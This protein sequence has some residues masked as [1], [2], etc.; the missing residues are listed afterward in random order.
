MTITNR[1]S[2][3]ASSAALK[4]PCVVATTA[5]ITLSALQTIDGVALASGDRVLVKNQTTDTE[6]G[7]WVADTGDW[8]RAEDFDGYDDVVTGTIMTVIQGTV[9][10]W[11][12]WRVTTSGDITPGTTSITIDSGFFDDAAMIY[13]IA[14]GT[15]AVQRTVQDKEREIIS[16]YDFLTTAQK[17]AVINDDY[18]TVTRAN[19]TTA[20]NNC[21]TAAT[22]AVWWPPGTYRV[23][24]I[25]HPDKVIFHRGSGREETI[26]QG[27]S[28][29][30][31]DMAYGTGL[32]QGSTFQDMAIRGDGAVSSEGTNIALDIDNV[33]TNLVRVQ[34]THAG[35]GIAARSLIGSNWH[36]V[37]AY[38]ED[39]GFRGLPSAAPHGGTESL[40]YECA[41]YYMTCSTKDGNTGTGTGFKVD[42]SF[43]FAGNTFVNLSSEYVGNGIVLD[44]DDAN[45]TGNTF[46]QPWVERVNPAGKAYDDNMPQNIW[47]QAHTQGTGSFSLGEGLQ[48]QANA[49]F[50]DLFGAA[51]FGIGAISNPSVG[52]YKWLGVQTYSA[53]EHAIKRRLWASN[54]LYVSG[55]SSYVSANSMAQD[56]QIIVSNGTMTG[57]NNIAT[58]TIS[59]AGDAECMHLEVEFALAGTASGA[60]WGVYKRVLSWNAANAFTETTIGTDVDVNATMT[61]TNTGGAARTV[62]IAVN[63]GAGNY[64][65][66]TRIRAF[67]GISGNA[68]MGVSIASLI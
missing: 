16:V 47:I 20:I 49:L 65:V 9:N 14:A 43:E 57:A 29:K 19:I 58:V 24:T 4:I 25:T 42:G 66:T 56:E 46:I 48:L 26:I 59:P 12:G 8:N 32:S 13:F 51:A 10:A 18:S 39:Y 15:G 1:L 45:D 54:S 5:N 33:G 52:V 44:G 41:V 38:G 17:D 64:R 6:N 68:Q 7:I 21:L 53:D 3:L 60:S 22:G 2:G 40:M 30:V 37:L 36:S 34:C 62:T 63:V 11:T 61:I 28:A 31:M 27:T 23:T 67:C 55:S 50:K 35:T